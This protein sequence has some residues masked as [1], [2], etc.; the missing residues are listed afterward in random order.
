MKDISI[1]ENQVLGIIDRTNGKF[2]TNKTK[3]MFPKK[4]DIYE[5]AD[6]NHISISDALDWYEL[7]KTRNFKTENGNKI[8]N[9]KGACT[10]WC[11]ARERKRIG[12]NQ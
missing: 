6:E 9:W 2:Q 12:G 8:N 11:R 1:L 5:L 4:D 10:N 3:G 7:H